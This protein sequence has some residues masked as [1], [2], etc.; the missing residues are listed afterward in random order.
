MVNVESQAMDIH[1]RSSKQAAWSFE[2]ALCVSRVVQ[3]LV[4]KR[5]DKTRRRNIEPELLHAL[6]YIS[7]LLRFLIS[8]KSDDKKKVMPEKPP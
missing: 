6:R 8:L 1:E 2:H 3:S 4:E 5:V 7:N